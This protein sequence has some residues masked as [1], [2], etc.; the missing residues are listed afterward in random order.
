MANMNPKIENL[1][2]PRFE[3]GQSGNPKGRPRS[4][5]DGFKVKLMGRSN[6][7]KFY[8]ITP[9]ELSEWYETLIT[10]TFSELKALEQNEETPA[11]IKNYIRAI[12]SDMSAG[13]T[14]TVDKIVERLYGKAIQRVEHT[15]ADGSDLMPART[16][17]KDE[18][19]ELFNDLEKDY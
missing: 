14:T 5:V 17:T 4:R 2:A 15:G 3:K 16:L 10:L 18:A 9:F 11:L 13:R 6:A 19:R 8:G 1:T 7:K 12:I